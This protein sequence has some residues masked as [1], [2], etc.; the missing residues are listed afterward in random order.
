VTYGPPPNQN[1]QQPQPP[2]GPAY[3]PPPPG[4]GPAASGRPG[5][6]LFLGIFAIVLAV[7]GVLF[8]RVFEFAVLLII[9]LGGILVLARQRAGAILITIG[10]GLMIVMMVLASTVPGL[11]RFFFRMRGEPEDDWPGYILGIAGLAA[12]VI[13]VLPPVTRALRGDPGP[14][15]RPP[16]P[17]GYGPPP[18]PGYG[19]P[20]GYPPPGYGPGGPPPPGYGPAGSPPRR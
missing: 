11:D 3:Q 5:I 10:T 15:Q 1:W 20:P 19:P 12:L 18:A 8:G 17:P 9:L 4:Y 16:A 6:V 14:S 13:S 7:A 2:P